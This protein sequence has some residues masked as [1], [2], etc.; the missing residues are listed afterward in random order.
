MVKRSV[1]CLLLGTCVGPGVA[2]ADAILFSGSATGSWDA[3]AGGPGNP[4]P[5]ARAVDADAAA[6]G[7][8]SLRFG[9][10]LF[11]PAVLAFD[12]AGSDPRA[13]PGLNGVGVGQLFDIGR[14]TYGGGTILAGTGLGSA[15]LGID[16][17][18]TLPG[19]AV[20]LVEAYSLDFAIRPV[21]GAY[22]I[23]FLDTEAVSVS[24]GT[25]TSTFSAG[26][27][28]YT[29][30]LLGFSNDGRDMTTRFLAP[31]GGTVR[32][33]LYAVISPVLP[34]AVPVS[35]PVSVPVLMPISVP[36]P[37]SLALF[38]TGLLGLGLVWRRR[39]S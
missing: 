30:S 19:D 5:L 38:G 10:P 32:A 35:V 16:L 15:V 27:V 22:G 21:P 3:Y 13:A 4:F 12:G 34:V 14:F 20:P 36:E 1:L 17:A 2:R 37:G 8:A 23:P 39:R 33:D 9:L 31:D 7:T 25:T 24:G 6:G 11:A 29:L 28:A 18:L 26:G